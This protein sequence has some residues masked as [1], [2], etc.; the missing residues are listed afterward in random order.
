M[1]S[2]CALG[3]TGV[4][5]TTGALALLSA[6]AAALVLLIGEA[7]GEGGEAL[8]VAGI[9][10]VETGDAPHEEEE[11]R[12]AIKAATIMRFTTYAQ[13]SIETR[14]RLPLQCIEV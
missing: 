6:A 9:E 3:A 1:T 12:V 2:R 5:A 13:S 11:A 8:R 7:V 10:G 4:G 14:N